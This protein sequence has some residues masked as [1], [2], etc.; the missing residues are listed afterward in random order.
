MWQGIILA[1]ADRGP[2]IKEDFRTDALA[3]TED[4]TVRTMQ[5]T[6]NA[7]NRLCA[8]FVRTVACA[9]GKQIE[10]PASDVC[11]LRL[12]R[13]LPNGARRSH[14]QP[15]VTRYFFSRVAN[16]DKEFEAFDGVF[17]CVFEDPE[18]DEVVTHVLR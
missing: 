2:S 15:G 14:R 3:P 5:Q 13:P 11:K 16:A 12:M 9:H 4:I 10:Q 7:M 17:H 1:L 8:Q 18:R 6:L